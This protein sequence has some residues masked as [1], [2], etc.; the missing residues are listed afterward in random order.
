MHPIVLHNGFH[1]SQ[2]KINGWI[3]KQA[4]EHHA[5]TV[6]PLV[7]SAGDCFGHLKAD[8][9]FIGVGVISSWLLEDQGKDLCQGRRHRC[10]KGIQI[11]WQYLPEPLLRRILLFDRRLFSALLSV[12]AWH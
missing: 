7:F 12:C 8:K 5:C 6:A 11:L 2:G 10:S 9:A 3:S 1:G 4:I